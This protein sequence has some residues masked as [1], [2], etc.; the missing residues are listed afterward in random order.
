MSLHISLD[1]LKIHEVFVKH[2]SDI[3]AYAICV[4]NRYGTWL[5]SVSKYMTSQLQ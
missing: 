2:I 5:Q 4:N 1:L 3:V